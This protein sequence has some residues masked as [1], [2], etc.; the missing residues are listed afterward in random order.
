MEWYVYVEFVEKDELFRYFN[1]TK[2]LYI[3]P[4]NIHDEQ[5]TCFEVAIKIFLWLLVLAHE[6]ITIG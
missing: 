4:F 1:L 6:G 5:N 3:D 2:T